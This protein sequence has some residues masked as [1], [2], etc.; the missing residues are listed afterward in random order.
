MNYFRH[1][2][3]SAGLAQAGALGIAELLEECLPK[4]RT[5]ELDDVISG[6]HYNICERRTNKADLS[7]RWRDIRD[8]GAVRQESTE[9]GAAGQGRA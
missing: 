6:L 5:V 3:R 7:C 1:A 4:G 9:T 8:H 2:K